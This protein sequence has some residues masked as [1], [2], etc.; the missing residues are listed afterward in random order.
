MGAPDPENP[1]FLGFSVLRGGLRPWSQ[2]MVS[3]GARPWGRGRS[4]DCSLRSEETELA[5]N[6]AAK[7]P[8]LAMA[9]SSRNSVVPKT[10]FSIVRTHPAISAVTLNREICRF[11]PAKR[12]HILIEKACILFYTCK[13][14]PCVKF[15]R[16]GITP[17]KCPTVN[18]K[19]CEMCSRVK[20]WFALRFVESISGKRPPPRKTFLIGSSAK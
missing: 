17:E 15:Q 5:R 7:I 9:M 20:F 4:G 14:R 19:P 2:T 12:Q 1:L 13:L 10:L 8:S 11:R 16:I 18:E 3:E 6:A